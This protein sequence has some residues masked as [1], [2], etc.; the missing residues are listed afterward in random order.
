MKQFRDIVRAFTSAPDYDSILRFV[1]PLKDHFGINHFWYARI[2]FTGKHSYF[3]TTREQ[4]ED[5][6]NEGMVDHFATLRH[7]SLI[8]P[9]ISL[10]KADGDEKFQKILDRSWEKFQIHFSLTLNRPT[11]DGVESFGFGTQFK[12]PKIEEQL[13]NEAPVLTHFI[14]VFRQ[15]YQRFIRSVDEVEADLRE[16]LGPVFYEHPKGLQLPLDR[17]LFLREIGTHLPS[18]TSREIDIL[19]LL[20][21]GFPASY[22]GKKL[23]LSPR[24]IEN[25]L[26][27]LKAKLHCKDKVELIQKT[28][29]IAAT[30]YLGTVL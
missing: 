26:A 28:Q 10:M 23:H 9:G 30:G 11:P 4:V 25:Y 27:G 6:M 8:Q 1:K 5:C 21:N 29:D 17:S 19:K 16:Y 12:N 14:H 7:P 18:F 3:G 15:K 13:L 24:T 22:I 20:A 2:T